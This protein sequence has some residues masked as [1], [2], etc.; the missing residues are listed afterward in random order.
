L[1]DDEIST[2]SKLLSLMP[3]MVTGMVGF[4]IISMLLGTRSDVGVV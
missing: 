4:V 1:S 2:M 3:L